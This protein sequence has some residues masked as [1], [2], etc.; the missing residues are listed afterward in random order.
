LGSIR[1]TA[2]SA[3]FLKE[4]KTG[5]MS[6]VVR[7][8]Y[9]RIGRVGYVGRAAVFGL[10]GALVVNAAVSNQA[11]KAKGLDGALQKLER[12]ALR[13]R[14][15]ACDRRWARRLR[16][17]LAGRRSLPADLTPARRS[18]ANLVLGPLLRYTGRTMATVWVETDMACTVTVLGQRVDTFEI[19]GHHY[20]LVVLGGLAED[21]DHAYTVGLDDE[22]VW[23][24][25]DGRP[26]SVI[27]TR[28]GERRLRLIFGSCR[29]GAPQR[30][31]Y[32]SSP[33]VDEAG[34][35]VDA[36]WAFSRRLQTGRELWPDGLLLLGD[37]VYRRG[38]AGDCCFHPL[39][40]RRLATAGRGSGRFRGVHAALPR[41]VERPRYPLVDVD[42]A[43]GDAVRRPRRSGRLEHLGGVA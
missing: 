20:A 37:Q 8:W 35:G 36:L 21:A 30:P 23:P 9:E 15:A 19:G 42:R 28:Q 5:Q 31:P 33:S 2:A 18:V 4:A 27:R 1:R 13:R 32:T 6:A 16:R 22:T 43:G 10:V 39:A 38:V 34:F 14:G 12:P 26:L 40:T 3:D 24:L 7:R 41:S 25:D 17:L 29:V 11:E